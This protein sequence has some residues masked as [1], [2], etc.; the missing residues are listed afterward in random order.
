M[1]LVAAGGSLI[2]VATVAALV[3]GSGGV[4]IWGDGVSIV[5][6]IGMSVAATGGG[7]AWVVVTITPSFARSAG[8]LV[9]V[10]APSEDIGGAIVVERVSVRAVDSTSGYG[11]GCIPN[12]V[13][14]GAVGS[15]SGVGSGPMLNV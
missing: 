10:A 6:D 5:R 11:S 3:V 13:L 15:L 14:V 8:M 12:G 7:G 1:I 4:F 9:V 2:V